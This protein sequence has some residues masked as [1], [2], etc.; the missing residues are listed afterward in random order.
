MSANATKPKMTESIF[1]IWYNAI[2]LLGDCLFQIISQWIGT[3]FQA[4]LLGMLKMVNFS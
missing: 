3:F 2:H 1:D 4:F